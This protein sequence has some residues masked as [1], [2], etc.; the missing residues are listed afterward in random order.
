MM[1]ENSLYACSP[2]NNNG[3]L[4]LKQEQAINHT[5]YAN[6]FRACEVDVFC[7]RE[8]TSKGEE[9]RNIPYISLSSL[10]YLSRKL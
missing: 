4:E 9:Y 3:E 10:E 5:R 6:T 2:D 1:A 7:R 8:G